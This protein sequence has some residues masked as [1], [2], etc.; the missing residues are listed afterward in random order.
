MSDIY[1]GTSIYKPGIS[2]FWLVRPLLGGIS[3]P[4]GLTT[5]AR[6]RVQEGYMHLPAQSAKPKHKSIGGHKG[7][8]LQQS[9][10]EIDVMIIKYNMK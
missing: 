5:T 3:E 10:S 9:S 1:H 2:T 6:G 7:Y 8:S 4:C